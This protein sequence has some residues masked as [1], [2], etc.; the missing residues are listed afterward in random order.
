MPALDR[1]PQRR[2]RPEDVRL[3][4]QLVEVPWP[5][6]NRERGVGAD[7][8]GGPSGVISGVEQLVAHGPGV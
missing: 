1:R 7:R 3:P 5:H 6:P 2:P 8:I 4:D